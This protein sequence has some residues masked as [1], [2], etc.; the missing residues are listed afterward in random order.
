MTTVSVSAL[1]MTRADTRMITALGPISVPKLDE[2][3]DTLRELAVRGAGRTPVGLIPAITSHLWDYDPDR[4]LGDLVE[5][6][7]CSV[8]ELPALLTE[9]AR[10]VGHKNAISVAVAGDY[11]ILDMCHGLGDGRLITMINQVLGER[12]LPHAYP[13]WSFGGGTN[14]PLER[15]I[16]GFYGSDPRRAGAMLRARRGAAAIAIAGQDEPTL[17]WSRLPAVVAAR[18]NGGTTDELRRHRDRVSPGLSVA[19]IIFSSIVA[20]M[21][22]CGVELA[23]TV[24]VIFDCRRYLPAARRV[25]GNFV[26]GLDLPV[27]DP[28]DPRLLN[29][30]IS[31]AAACGRPLA[32]L[33]MSTSSFR[34][35]YR[36]GDGYVEETRVPTHPRARLAFSDIGQTFPGSEMWLSG[37]AERFYNAVNEP[38]APE[39]IVF[40]ITHRGADFDVTASFHANV[41]SPTVIQTAL[42]NVAH[43]PGRHFMHEAKDQ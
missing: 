29:R 24:N 28:G 25:L 5:L 33:L 31:E 14:H 11:L 36:R 1:D 6:P 21:R 37:R 22:S 10:R 16:A 17:P 38:K 20:E 2:I 41:F 35:R 42:D 43:E 32:A 27:A 18:T 40:T 15:A 3:A 7:A 12:P 19:S 8:D 34:G 4:F 23:P 13:D 39:A 30:A 26:S 9:Q